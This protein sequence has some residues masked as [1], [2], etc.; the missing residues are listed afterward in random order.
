M[1]QTPCW[2]AKSSSAFCSSDVIVQP[3]GLP[4]ELTKIARVRSSVRENLLTNE[5]LAERGITNASVAASLLANRKG[6]LAERAGE[7]DDDR[8]VVVY[9]RGGN[10]SA[11]A[12]E[13]LTAAGYEAAKLSEGIVGWDEADLPLEPEGGRVAESGE[14]A[15]VLHAAGRLPPGEPA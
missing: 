15:E 5:Q 2:R 8:P 4:G 9:C 10:R 13:A 1:I 3:V 6:W 7:I 11:M 14:A 12:A